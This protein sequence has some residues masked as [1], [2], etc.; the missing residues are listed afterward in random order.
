MFRLTSY[1]MVAVLVLASA[2]RASIVD[3]VF[4]RGS[5]KIG[6]VGSFE[7]LGAFESASD[8]V[9]YQNQFW[10]QPMSSRLYGPSIFFDGTNYYWAERQEYSTW[11]Y[12]VHNYGPSLANMMNDVGADTQQYSRQ[13]VW[14]Q[15][16]GSQGQ[17]F[18]DSDG[19]IYNIFYHDENTAV[20]NGYDCIIR[21]GSMSDML[22]SNGT[23]YGCTTYSF[24]DK[25]FGVNGKYYRTNTDGYDLIGIA[26]YNSFNDLLA[27]HWAARYDGGFGKSSDLF[28][29]VPRSALLS[30][31]EP[32]TSCMA[33]AGLA[34]GGY[35][36]FRRRRR[37]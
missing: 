10:Q 34:C 15:Y 30:V 8:M 3:P 17:W 4:I 7:N 16:S 20:A 28:L 24:S 21:Y 37:A 13:T 9:A 23:V 19:A 22:A 5:K 27:D 26:E 29:A 6:W 25:F 36:M 11:W 32:S 14:G 2:A 35:S 33:L 18:G 12:W 1:A 31:P